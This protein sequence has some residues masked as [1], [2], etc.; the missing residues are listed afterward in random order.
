MKGESQSTLSFDTLS[1]AVAVDV[2][3]YTRCF[4]R[5]LYMLHVYSVDTFLLQRR[6]GNGD[7]TE[8]PSITEMLDQ[9]DD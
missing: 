3:L 7:E 4:I 1:Q 6:R 2:F 8:R 9:E 5:V